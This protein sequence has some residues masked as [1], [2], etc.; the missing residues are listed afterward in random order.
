MESEKGDPEHGTDIIAV[1]IGTTTVRACLFN[2]QCQL[3]DHVEQPTLV[4]FGGTSDE[5][6]RAEIDPDFL[7]NQFVSLISELLKKTGRDARR[8][9]GMGICCQRNTFICWDKESGKPC[10]KFI[11]W[12]DCRARETCRKWNNSW[13]VKAINVIGFVLHLLT[14]AARFK[15]ARIFSFLNAMVTH[16]L[17][18]TLA[19]DKEMQR[20][21]RHGQLAFGCLDTWLIYKLSSGT[22]HITEPS[23]ASSTG[24]F[25]PYV[26]DWGYNILSL[27]SFPLS[28]LPRHTFSA[29]MRFAV[30][31]EELFG[32]PFALAAAVTSSVL[33]SL[34]AVG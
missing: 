1:D 9:A 31:D 14:R 11:T 18:V 20:L 6:I 3:I 34:A 23:N 19:E 27:I 16:R 22:I 29:G 30:V 33:S 5:G 17:M 21:L 24:L 8:V 26:M 13:T 25:D 7:W 15:A 32:A 12:K 4:Q 2:P 28:V 10:H